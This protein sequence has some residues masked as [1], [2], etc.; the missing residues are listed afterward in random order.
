VHGLTEVAGERLQLIVRAG[1][2]GDVQ[3]GDVVH[4]SPEPAG[5]HVFD[6]ETGARLG[7]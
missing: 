5:V 1:A 3:R 6:T 4:V 2:R 7:D